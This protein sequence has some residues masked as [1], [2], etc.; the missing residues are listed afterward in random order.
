[1]VTFVFRLR[2]KIK[3]AC[4]KVSD[5]KPILYF[6]P[7]ASL[8]TILFAPRVHYKRCEHN[9]YNFDQIAS[10]K[11]K[12]GSRHLLANRGRLTRPSSLRYP[13]RSL[14]DALDMLRLLPMTML[15]LLTSTRGMFAVFAVFAM[16][17]SCPATGVRDSHFQVGVL[18]QA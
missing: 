2:S 5:L 10:L 17:F 9:Q 8:D 12:K 18:V 3:A 4:C 13:P 1:M 15:R 14:F 11:A 7:R 6:R 16:L